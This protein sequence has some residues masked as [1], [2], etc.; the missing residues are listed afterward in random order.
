MLNGS[1]L[2][3]VGDAYFELRVRI[4]LLDNLPLIIDLEVALS[5]NKILCFMNLKQYLTTDEMQYFLRGRNNA[6]HGY[7]KNVDHTTYIVST[8]FEAVIG[9]LYLK[10]EKERLDELIEMIFSIVESGE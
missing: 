2:A 1:N 4:H 9:Y 6:P 3:Y 7:R 8:G 10:G 5:S